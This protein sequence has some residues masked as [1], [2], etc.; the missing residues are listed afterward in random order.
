MLSVLSTAEFGRDTTTGGMFLMLNHALREQRIGVVSLEWNTEAV[1]LARVD[2]G[3]S[4]CLV[5]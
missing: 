1:T 2:W 5:I 4:A 3:I